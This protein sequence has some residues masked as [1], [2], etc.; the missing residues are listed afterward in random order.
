MR[1]RKKAFAKVAKTLF[2]RYFSIFLVVSLVIAFSV[3]GDSARTL[4]DY[5]N[6]LLRST[7]LITAVMGLGFVMT[8]GG[9]DLSIGCQVSLVSVVI[10]SMSVAGFPDVLVIAGALGTGVLCGL[11]N[12]VLV[13]Y[14]GIVPFAATIATQVIF[15]GLSYLLYGGRMVSHMAAAIRNITE[16]NFL[17]IRVDLW[18]VLAVA[19]F[20]YLYMHISFSGKHLRAVGLDE[21]AAKRAGVNV[22]FVKCMSYCIA[23]FLYA[24]AAMILVSRIGYAGSS[25]GSGM[26]ITAI[27]A[28]YVGGGMTMAERPQVLT[29]L[30]GSFVVALIENGFSGMGTGIYVQYIMT[31]V[32]LIISMTLHKWRRKRV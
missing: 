18:L 23:G 19:A 2:S 29:L 25:T 24:V 11:L 32:V 27:M 20:L 1:E 30:L 3:L 8:C 13:G 6:V 7:A 31:G 22:K 9:I 28:A 15:R 17:L 14:M 5:Y 12:G 4:K 21:A 16:V 26:E 10:S